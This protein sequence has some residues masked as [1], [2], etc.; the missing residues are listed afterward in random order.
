VCEH[1]AHVVDELEGLL[2]GL[3]DQVEV[4]REAT[5]HAERV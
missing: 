2:R 1:H 3:V 4:A 5:T